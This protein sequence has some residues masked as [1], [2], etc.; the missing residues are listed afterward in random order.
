M[1]ERGRKREKKGECVCV[2]GDVF[3]CVRTFPYVCVLRDERSRERNT[4]SALLLTANVVVVEIAVAVAHTTH[5]CV[6]YQDGPAVEK[7]RGK[8]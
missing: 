6:G 4:S 2:F 3:M 8:I 7:G 1:F 5:A